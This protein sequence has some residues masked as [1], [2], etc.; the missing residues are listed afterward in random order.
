MRYYTI[1]FSN[2]CL[3]DFSDAVYAKSQEKISLSE[4]TFYHQMNRAFIV[5]L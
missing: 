5:E 3:Y 4:M 2:Y 1:G